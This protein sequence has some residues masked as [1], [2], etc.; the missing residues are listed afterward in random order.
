MPS[1]RIRFA[2]EAA[3]LVVVAL[4]LGLARFDPLVIAGVMFV[5]AALVALLER[6]IAKEAARRIGLAAEEPMPPPHVER[7]DVQSAEPERALEPELEATVSERSARAILASAHGRV[8]N[9]RRHLHRSPTC[10]PIRSWR[11]SS[12]DRRES[13]TSGS[14]NAQFATPP[15]TT[16][17]RNGVPSSSTCASS[18][19]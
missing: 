19:T 16:A 8:R 11:P 14:S 10:S 18:R 6:A 3:F 17:A 1:A 13:G 2:G 5:A 15:A 4:G 12:S 7:I 9:H